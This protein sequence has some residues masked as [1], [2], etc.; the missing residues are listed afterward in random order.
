[1]GGDHLL[2]QQQGI[3]MIGQ[4][5]GRNARQHRG[6]GKGIAQW[7]EVLRRAH[8]HDQNDGRDRRKNLKE[9]S[10]AKVRSRTAPAALS[11]TCVRPVCGLASGCVMASRNRAFP[12]VEHSGRCGFSTR[13]P[14]RGQ[15]RNL[16][17]NGPASLFHPCGVLPRAPEATRRLVQGRAPRNRE[18][19]RR[20]ATHIGCMCAPPRPSQQRRTATRRLPTWTRLERLELSSSLPPANIRLAHLN[21]Y[22]ITSF[23][24]STAR[25]RH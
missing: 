6:Q 14:L 11:V 7:I 20:I 10:T 17:E 22:D 5:A 12:C 8:P 4:D 15:R 21:C 9:G 24:K 19:R 18:L 2:A 23:I 3:A 13:L 25:P 1:A 16:R